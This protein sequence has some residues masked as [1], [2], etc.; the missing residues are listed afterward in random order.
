[1]PPLSVTQH[2]LLPLTVYLQ[3]PEDLAVEQ[4]AVS[5]HILVLGVP[6]SPDSLLALLAPL[7]SRCLRQWRPIVIVDEQMPVAGS[8]WDAI[9]EFR[10][11]YFIEV[12][13]CRPVSVC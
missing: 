8:G 9:A 1:M 13:S 7:R 11:V 4:A 6:A 3:S 5:G 12:G 10:D 2:H